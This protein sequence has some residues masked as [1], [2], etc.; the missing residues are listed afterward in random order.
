MKQP[1]LVKPELLSII[2]LLI[3]VSMMAC[4]S[5]FGII[6][7]IQ[8]DRISNNFERIEPYSAS[9]TNGQLLTQ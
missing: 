2:S 6:S 5:L 1:K 7:I 9:K 8:T 3:I 4:A